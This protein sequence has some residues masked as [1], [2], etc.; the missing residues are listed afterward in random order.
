MVN[1]VA[2]AVK[3]VHCHLFVMS[4]ERGND[5]WIP[6]N[7]LSM[8][9]QKRSGEGN[10]EI[11]TNSWYNLDTTLLCNINYI[12]WMKRNILKLYDYHVGISN[13]TWTT[14]IHSYPD[15]LLQMGG[16]RVVS[17]WSRA[18]LL[19]SMSCKYWAP[20]RVQVTGLPSFL[21]RSISGARPAAAGFLTPKL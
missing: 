20:S 19:L 18:D 6:N 17:G 15:P 4:S 10:A 16:E 14:I 13:L 7:S 8:G 2:A 12:M 3:V 11:K 5:L 9:M 21:H 1:M